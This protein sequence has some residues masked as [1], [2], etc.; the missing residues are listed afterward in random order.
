MNLRTKQKETR[1]L[2]EGAYGGRGGG[3][4]GGGTVREAGMDMGTLLHFTWRTC[5]DLLSSTGDSA[6][7]HVAAWLGGEFGGECVCV[8]G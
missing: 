2:G 4:V 1:R 6:Q 8:Y 5:K 3:R 7:C